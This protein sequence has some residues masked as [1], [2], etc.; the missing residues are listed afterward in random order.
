MLP[1]G[2]AGAAQTLLHERD[3]ARAPCSARAR[4]R[5]PAAMPPRGRPRAHRTRR[6]SGRDARRRLRTDAISASTGSRAASSRWASAGFPRS[7]AIVYCER[8][9]VPIEK[10]SRCGSELAGLERGRRH[11]DHRADLDRLRGADVAARRVEQPAR[12]EDLVERGDHREHH[13]DGVLGRDAQDGAQLRREEVGVHER[14]AQPA[15]SRGTG[16]PPARS[17]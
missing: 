9:L 17:R 1:L 13:G 5:Q 15:A 11:L 7:A 8:S 10:K 16:S 3:P 6:P 14:E 4:R 12:R 2:S